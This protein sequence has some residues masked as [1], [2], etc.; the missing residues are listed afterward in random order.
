MFP[1]T[2]AD[3]IAHDIRTWLRKRH[4]NSWVPYQGVGQGTDVGL[5][6]GDWCDYINAN[7]GRG[8]LD[9]PAKHFL[10]ETFPTAEQLKGKTIRCVGGSMHGGFIINA[11]E[12]VAFD[13]SG[14]GGYTGGGLQGL[15]IRLDKDLG[16]TEV[17]PLRLKGD[18]NY[19]PSSMI[20]NDIKITA[21]TGTDGG[22]GESYW[23]KG[24]EVDGSLKTTGA[25]GIRETHMQNVRVFRARDFAMKFNNV[26]HC[27]MNDIG[28]YTGTGA[29]GNDIIFENGSESL[30]V[31]G[32]NCNGRITIDDITKTQLYGSCGDLTKAGS[33]LADIGGLLKV[34]GSVT[35]TIPNGDHLTII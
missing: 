5:A 31:F 22:A 7:G 4:G 2:A 25:I 29:T 20:F 9:I 6:L 12:G 33:S 17:Q 13:F 15:L 27:V 24:L 11:T 32:I 34:S 30:Y 8:T 28:S 1:F 10:L 35:G 18:A 3:P 19:Q 26:I 16:Q 23:G 14:Y 21:I